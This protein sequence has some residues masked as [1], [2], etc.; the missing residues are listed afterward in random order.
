[1]TFEEA[2]NLKSQFGETFEIAEK[3]IGKVLVVPL[4]EKDLLNYVDDF[5]VNKFD[6]LT[7]KRYS[8]NSKFKVCAIWTDGANVMKKEI[9]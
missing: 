8:Q 7:A 5:R 4:D 3:M 6:D 2:L 1:M 9:Q